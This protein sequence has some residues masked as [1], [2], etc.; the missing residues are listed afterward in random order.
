MGEYEERYPD[1]YGRDETAGQPSAA[2]DLHLPPR[3]HRQST[4]FNTRFGVGAATET[5][6]TWQHGPTDQ[7]PPAMPEG[8]R[9]IE[10]T[11]SPHRTRASY[12]GLGPRGYVRSDQRIYEDI[13]DRLTEN[14]FIDASDITVSV[15]DRKVTLAGSV[16]NML[17]LHQAEEITREAAGVADL[18]NDL[19]VDGDERRDIAP[20]DRVNRAM[21]LRARDR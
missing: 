19:L 4:L 12:R 17:A 18:R 13:C 6:P 10:P 9:L 3:Q 2:A 15:R 5:A 1:A 20:G 7:T 14:P 21:P 16:D 11:A 8:S